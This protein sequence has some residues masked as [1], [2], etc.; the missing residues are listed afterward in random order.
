MSVGSHPSESHG[1]LVRVGVSFAHFHTHGSLQSDSIFKK[2]Y[3]SFQVN[4]T[5][6]SRT[7]SD[8]DLIGH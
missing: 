5:F 1:V 3:S 6:P 7:N 4:Q 2:N 8:L